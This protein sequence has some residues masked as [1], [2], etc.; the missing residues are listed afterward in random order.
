MKNAARS[1]RNPAPARAIR[2]RSGELSEGRGR[3]D[4]RQNMAAPSSHRAERPLTAGVGAFRWFLADARRTAYGV[5]H[6]AA[7]RS[8]GPW[9]DG[10]P[11]PAESAPG[12]RVSHRGA[13][14]L[15]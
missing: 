6:V 14:G 1:S 2:P 5:S 9:D 10:P 15:A 7:A 13:G 11:R 4:V 8:G 12:R 3:S